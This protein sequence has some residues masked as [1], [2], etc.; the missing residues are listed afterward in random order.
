MQYN[1]SF[2]KDGKFWIRIGRAFLHKD[3]KG[4]IS[5]CIDSIPLN[6]DGKCVL[7][8]RADREGDFGVDGI[9]DSDT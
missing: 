6:W 5:M 3:N 1:V 7:F 4:G 2:K 8:P 9:I